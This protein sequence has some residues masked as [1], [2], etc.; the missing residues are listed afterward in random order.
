MTI[1]LTFKSGGLP[2]RK[3]K[4]CEEKTDAGGGD[5]IARFAEQRGLFYTPQKMKKEKTILL[6]RWVGWLGHLGRHFW[7][8]LSREEEEAGAVLHLY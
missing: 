8:R 3:W 1:P 6:R 4:Y 5:G 2:A 7:R